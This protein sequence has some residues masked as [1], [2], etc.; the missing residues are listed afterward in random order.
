MMKPFPGLSGGTYKEATPVADAQQSLNCFPERIESGSGRSAGMMLPTP[1]LAAFATAIATPV[2]GGVRCVYTDKA[3]GRCFMI[4]DT[5]FGEVK[6]DGSFTLIYAGLV[7]DGLPAWITSNG[8]GGNQLYLGSAG[9]GYIYSMTSGVFA[10]IASAYPGNTS[11]GIFFDQYFVALK[12]NSSQF[13]LSK[14]A[15][16]TVWVGTDV[17]LNRVEGTDN[18][19]AVI[20]NHREMWA[21][22]TDTS[23]VFFNSGATFPMVNIPGVFIEIGTESGWT[24]ALQD[25]TL[26]LLGRDERGGRVVYGFNAYSP[27]R[28]SSHGVEWIWNGFANASDAIAWTYEEAGH[29]FYVLYFPSANRTFVYDSAT[30]LWHERAWLNPATGQFEAFRG[31]CHTVAFGKHLVGDTQT[32]TLFEMSQQIYGDLGQPVVRRRRMPHIAASG[33]MMTFNAAQLILDNGQGLISGQGSKPLVMLRV[34]DDG[35]RTWS[36]EMLA[37]AWPMGNYSMD[38]FRT[39]WYPLG[40]SADRIFEISVSDQIPWRFVEFDLDI[41]GG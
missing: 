20:R 37:D 29:A 33:D 12:K 40:S 28:V 2:Q 11:M 26:Y 35:G 16:G 41:D 9:T 15:D 36:E 7:N 21:I 23:E 1:G 3:T 4:T 34:S 27:S 14:L 19:A 39:L 31:R 18:F 38:R 13:N 10:V 6:A 24:P 22:G 30:K 32:G 17:F 25:N 8:K 5:R